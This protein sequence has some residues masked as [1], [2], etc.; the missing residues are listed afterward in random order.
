[1]FVLSSSLSLGLI[2]GISLLVTGESS[3]NLDLDL[4]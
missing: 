3:M 2:L 1:M 4:D